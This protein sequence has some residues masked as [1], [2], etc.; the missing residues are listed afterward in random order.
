VSGADT[1]FSQPVSF[2]VSIALVFI[3]PG[4]AMLGLASTQAIINLASR[5]VVAHR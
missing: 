5:R 4:R 3:A 1:A 2:A